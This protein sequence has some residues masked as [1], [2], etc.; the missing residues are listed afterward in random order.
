M[1]SNMAKVKPEQL[2]QLKQALDL[3]KEDAI[4]DVS[5]SKKLA[6]KHDE[7]DEDKEETLEEKRKDTKILL[8]TLGCVIGIIIIFAVIFYFVSHNEKTL[9]IDDMHALNIEGKLSPSKGYM[10]NGYSFVKYGEL[11]Y[12]QLKKNT[13]TYDVT[14]NFDPKSVENITVEGQLTMDF[15]KGR[16]LYITFDP[17]GYDLKYIAVAN[18]GLSRSLSWA[19]SYN[20]T[21]ACTKNIT[22]A[23]EDAGVVN[24]GDPGK[25]VIYFKEDNETKI[26][27]DNTCVT[28]QGTGPELVR[29]KDRLLLRWYGMMN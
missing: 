23:C 2:K 15:I 13:T 8:I 3:E 20:M 4:V 12:S 16:H 29:A 5:K 26:T 6:K 21:A 14:F 17:E 18:F 10:Y 22:K 27:L 19:F 25:A 9:T 24:C 1:A 7:D 11:W 28:L